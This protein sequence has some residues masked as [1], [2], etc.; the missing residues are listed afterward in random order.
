MTNP[1]DPGPRSVRRH[2]PVLATQPGR[3]LARRLASVAVWARLTNG[4]L[5]LGE[6][7][8]EM[9][10]DAPSRSLLWRVLTATVST[11][12]TLAPPDVA[13]RAALSALTALAERMQEQI[14][15]NPPRPPRL[16]GRADPPQVFVL[17]MLVA[18]VQ[19]C[20]GRWLHRLEMW[21]EAGQPVTDWP[22]L[23]LC[24]D[25]LACTRERLVERAWQLA[26]ALDLAGLDPLLPARPAA[27]PSL[28]AE[29]QLAA[30]EAAVS[31][32]PDRSSLQAGWHI[33]IEALARI[34]RQAAPAGAGALGEAIA[35]LDALAGEI[36]G[37]LKAM[38]PP[39]RDGAD[40]TIQRL[41]L[42]LLG[43]QLLPFLAEW[44]PRFT[45]FAASGRPESKWRRAEECRAE[46][47]MT[48]ARCLATIG[49]LARRIGA[50]PPPGLAAGAAAD[51]AE[52][53]LQL[54]PPAMRS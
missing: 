11:I 19:P 47:A 15:A 12:G 27:V 2:L 44:Q 32:M 30:V 33:Y 53:R 22:L 36:R 16:P 9:V 29:D 41:G 14:A 45:R 54:P 43:E 13:P 35:S 18:D 28:I 10:L 7:D 17:A 8:A 24:R 4:S 42:N 51:E 37:E 20:L 23:G 1:T 50:P 3:F 52:V 21:C 26:M 25:D 48:R 31:P 6:P 5:R 38:P 34:P 46:L 40:D 49:E 39:A